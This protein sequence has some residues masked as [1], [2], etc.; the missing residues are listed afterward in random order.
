MLSFGK[1]QIQTR[2]PPSMDPHQGGLLRAS[3]RGCILTQRW[4]SLTPCTDHL[5]CPD[6]TAVKAVPLPAQGSYVRRLINVFWLSSNETRQ[7]EAGTEPEPRDCSILPWT[8]FRNLFAEV[9]SCPARLFSSKT[10][11]INAWLLVIMEGAGETRMEK[12]L[13]INHCIINMLVIQLHTVLYPAIDL[14]ASRTAV[15]GR[16]SAMESSF[17][18]GYCILDLSPFFWFPCKH[19]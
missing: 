17:K 14:H 9:S 1:A 15:S 18:Q 2:L 19:Q 11:L 13:Y 6:G 16:V 3:G 4:P 12:L 7:L 10:G 5:L 8:R